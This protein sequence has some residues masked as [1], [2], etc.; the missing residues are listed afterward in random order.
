MTPCSPVTSFSS[1]ASLRATRLIGTLADVQTDKPV[2]NGVEIHDRTR[3]KSG[4]TVEMGEI[5]WVIR[6]VDVPEKN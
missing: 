3:L 4:S 5:K 1:G 2:Y 6:S